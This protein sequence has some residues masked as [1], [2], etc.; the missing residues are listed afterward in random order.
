VRV[1]CRAGDEHTLARRAAA[2]GTDV[3]VALGGDGT[4]SNVARGI[5]D[6][7]RDTCLAL[8]AGGTGND[9][10]QNIGAPAHDVRATL[11]LVFSGSPRRI[12][13][14]YVNATPFLNS[15][16]VGF[17]VAVI[18]A[19]PRAGSS[20][21]RSAYLLTAGRKL[22][23]YRAIAVNGERFLVIVIGNG[24]RFGGGMLLAPGAATD[25]GLLDLVAVRD[26]GPIA[27]VRA[28]LAA[29][30]GKH[31]KLPAV[32]HARSARFD[33]RFES[34]PL[35][36]VDGELVQADRCELAVRCEQRRLRVCVTSP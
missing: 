22:W 23:R 31:L 14:G 32:E 9:L 7:G 1:T 4:W 10:A 20:L 13:V 28:L 33:L 5:L 21:G 36:E 15:C 35:Y 25:D 16:G 6:A 34:A 17:D 18:Q 24:A 8:L 26:V 27:R 3:I 29:P 19:L 30:R 11:D 2:A 12:D